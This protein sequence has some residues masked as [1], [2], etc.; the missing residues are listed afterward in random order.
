LIGHAAPAFAHILQ[1]QVPYV[2]SETL[3]QA[4][5]HATR[6]AA[7]FVARTGKPAVVLLSPACASFDQFTNFEERGAA[8]VKLVSAWREAA[9]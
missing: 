7:A 5:Q 9:C 4:V 1:G 3:D 2:M 8:F 6:D